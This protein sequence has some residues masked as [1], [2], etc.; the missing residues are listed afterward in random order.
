M[1]ACSAGATAIG[2][3]RDLILNGQARLMIAG[4]V[5][6]MCRITYAA[7]NAFKSLD[8]EVCHP[9]DKDREGLSLG[10]AAAIMVLEPWRR[11]WQ[12]R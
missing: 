7:F 5:E 11:L 3:A 9:F 12:R 2:Y 1:T 4:G 6:P 10:E 8:P